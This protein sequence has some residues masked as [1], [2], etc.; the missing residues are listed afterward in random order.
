MQ[1]GKREYY[2]FYILHS[3]A[4]PRLVRLTGSPARGRFRPVASVQ[5][6]LHRQSDELDRAKPQRSGQAPARRPVPPWRPPRP[7]SLCAKEEEANLK[8]EASQN[9]SAEAGRGWPR[10]WPRLE[11]AL[12]LIW[13]WRG[14]LEGESVKYWPK[15]ALG[16]AAFDIARSPLRACR[17]LDSRGRGGQVKQRRDL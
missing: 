12:S 3:T 8:E 9:I 11:A 13:C 7:R 17:R 14:G 1:N 5:Y 15:P 4:L 6:A 10:L 2:Y 16:E